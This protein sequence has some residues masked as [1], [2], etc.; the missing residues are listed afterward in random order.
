MAMRKT[1]IYNKI[2]IFLEARSTKQKER[3]Y[4]E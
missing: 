3:K 2:L 1:Q 4:R